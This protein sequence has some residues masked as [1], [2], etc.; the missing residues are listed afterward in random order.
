MRVAL[1]RGA[2]LGIN[3][4]CVDITERINTRAQA[5]GLSESALAKESGIA[6]TTLQRRL[7]HPEDLTLREL[8]RLSDVL[9]TNLLKDEDAA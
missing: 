6:R 8:N 2:R 1:F 9:G 4:P 3:V 7:L 5:L